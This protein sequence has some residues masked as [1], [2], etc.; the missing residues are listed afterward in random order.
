MWLEF[1]A[2][3]ARLSGYPVIEVDGWRRRGHGEMRLCEGV[4]GH[5]TATP[6]SAKGNYPSLAVVRDGRAGLAGPL[7]ALGLGR[8]GGPGYRP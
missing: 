7:S 2:D 8:D 1:L 3:A 4:V 6:A 5:H